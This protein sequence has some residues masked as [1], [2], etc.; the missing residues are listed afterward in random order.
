ME[1]VCTG[2]CLE[3][4]SPVRLFPIPFRYLA[5]DRQFK[6]YQWIEVPITKSRKDSRPE[7]YRI[8]SRRIRILGDPIPSADGW[9]QRRQVIF[10]QDGWHFA[11]L[12]QLRAAQA[13][14]GQSLGMVRVG[15]VDKIE[16]EVRSEEEREGFERKLRA[17]KAQTDAFGREVKDLA[18]IPERIRLHW[19]CATDG[20]DIECLGHSASV[21][22]WGL[23]ELGRRE[24]CGAM[25][26]RMEEVCNLER[27][28]LHLF[29]GNIKRHPHIFSIVG[30]WY[31][32]QREVAQQ[33]LF[34]P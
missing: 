25:E 11:C 32:L 23:S 1:T 2:G 7:S 18:F 24:G 16:R 30:L 29:M 22:D 13:E 34:T 14:T 33:N 6:L 19:Q 20:T 9:Q 12:E 8:D 31:P 28:D 26:A 17:K 4:G 10:R 5:G 27:Y 21:L 3:D 15:Q